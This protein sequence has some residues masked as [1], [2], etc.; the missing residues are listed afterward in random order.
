MNVL[1]DTHAFLWFL[2]GDAQLSAR[3]REAIE[4]AGNLKWVSAASL[5]EM[6][7]KIS[8]GRLKCAQP[9]DLFVSSQMEVNGFLLL[10]IR[11]YHPAKL[12]DLPFRHRDPFDRMLVAQS[13]A[14]EFTLLSV[15]AAV[16]AYGVMRVW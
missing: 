15:D 5:W 11:T 3:A 8:L 10:P 9:F 16:D 14:E 4:D 2:E 6:A 12:L 13:L 7:I 1:L